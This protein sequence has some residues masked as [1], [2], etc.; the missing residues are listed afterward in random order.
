MT[1]AEREDMRLMTMSIRELRDELRRARAV[2]RRV[3]AGEWNWGNCPVCDTGGYDAPD[4]HAATC[5]LAAVL[6]DA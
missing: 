1:D 4:G 5:E 2:L 3:A 6:G